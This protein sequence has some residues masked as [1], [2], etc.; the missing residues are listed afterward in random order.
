MFVPIK[1]IFPLAKVSVIIPVKMAPDSD[2]LVLALATLGRATKNTNN[3]ICVASP[4]VAKA[5]TVVTVVC[6]CRQR[7]C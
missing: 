4:K 6:H 3:P 2:T 1:A 5:S 7:F